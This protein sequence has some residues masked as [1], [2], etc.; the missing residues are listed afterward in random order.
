ML[1]PAAAVTA[2]ASAAAAAGIAAVVD[3]PP[4][5][6]VPPSTVGVKPGVS[7]SAFGLGLRIF[8]VP[9][10]IAAQEPERSL[11]SENCGGNALLNLVGEGWEQLTGGPSLASG[12]QV[13]DLRDVLRADMVTDQEHVSQGREEAVL[14]RLG[15]RRKCLRMG[16]FERVS[17][18]RA[19][20]VA[21]L[22]HNGVFRCL[23]GG[24]SL[25]AVLLT[26][27]STHGRW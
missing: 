5:I 9:G 19:Q 13:G 1:A 15:K 16:G 6:R 20:K 2:D 4:P 24:L 12:H 10:L 26:R 22:A 18:S 7:P 21:V 27:E 11:G 25:R 17:R 23:R 3:V 14:M 8:T